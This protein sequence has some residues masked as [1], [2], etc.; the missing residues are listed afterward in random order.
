MPTYIVT[1]FQGGTFRTFETRQQTINGAIS[2]AES[3]GVEPETIRCP[4]TREVFRKEG[5]EW[6][7]D[8]Y[9]PPKKIAKPGEHNALFLVSFFLPPIGLV[10]GG[11]RAA[12]GMSGGVGAL[13]AAAIGAAAY[14]IAYVIASPYL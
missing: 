10:W 11:I 6:T 14:G 7:V 2:H 3:L 12:C 13:I 4:A 5:K 1:G 8:K 9:L